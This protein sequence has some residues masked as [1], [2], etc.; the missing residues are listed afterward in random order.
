MSDH[1]PTPDTSG[2]PD[3]LPPT[4]PAPSPLPPR[5]PTYGPPTGPAPAGPPSAEPPTGEP[6]SAEPAAAEP[7]APEPPVA[8][9]FAAGPPPFPPSTSAPAFGGPPPPPP[10]TVHVVGQDGAGGGWK[11][12]VTAG[13]TAVLIAGGAVFLITNSSDGA[14]ATNAV[15]AGATNGGYGNRESGFRRMG[16]AGTIASIDGS[17]LT[18]TEQARPVGPDG[19]SNDQT[20][21]SS[22]TVT[23][24]ATDD[25]TITETVAGSLS[26]VKV[27]DNVVVIGESAD[28]T[29][30]ARR[31]MDTGDLT[32]IGVGGKSR[33]GS[34]MPP[35]GAPDGYGKPPA[36]VPAPDGAGP[37]GRPP[38]HA[39]TGAPTDPTGR[40][41]GQMTTG[42]VESV[43]GSTVNVKTSDG[44][45]VAVATNADTTI[46]V[47]RKI[48]LSD[49]EVGDTISVTG[50]TDNGTVAATAIR[51][52]EL[53]G[54]GG[55][56]HRSGGRSG[57]GEPG[58]TTTTQP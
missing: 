27:G 19:E 8:E 40:A 29:F 13:V 24:T 44:T 39:P 58:Q 41:G 2:Q 11:P 22:T 36:D 26:D 42:T 23:V 3:P 47:T 33:S 35:A 20:T 45:V 37:G 10:E 28:G 48:A 1:E 52:G 49:L 5:V 17:T 50:E 18:V 14:S 6:P 16:T 32:D 46:T 56:E 55:F 9:P 38:T 21:G 12:W 53:R 31:I 54:A 43:D 4:A 25:T 51:K 7:S 34:A 57:S 15:P 30:T